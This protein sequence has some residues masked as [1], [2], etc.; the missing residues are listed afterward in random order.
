M[1]IPNADDIFGNDAYIRVEPI[2]PDGGAYKLGAVREKPTCSIGGALHS[3]ERPPPKKPWHA[4][5]NLMAWGFGTGVGAM[6]LV[7]M[8]VRR[9]VGEQLL[10]AKL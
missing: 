8:L 10:P 5:G 6:L 7:A 4:Y 9:I 3:Y 2:C 1:E